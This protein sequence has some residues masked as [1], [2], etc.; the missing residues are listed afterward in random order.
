MS[1]ATSAACDCKIG[2]NAEAYGL[3]ALDSDIRRRRE[4][5]ASLRS[6][7]G[8]VNVRLL[9]AEL[10]EADADVVGDAESVYEAIEGDDVAPERR[11]D[12]RDQLSYAGVDLTALRDDFVSHQTVSAHLNDCLGLDTSRRGVTTVEEA[13]DLI[14]WASDKEERTIEQTLA[15]LV[16]NGTLTLGDL[17][18]TLS[19]TVRCADCGDSFRVP[20][21][22]ERRRCSCCL[23]K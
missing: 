9:E 7:A 14:A 13:R 6:L 3:D 5:G 18:V 10:L 23:P 22:L 21:I 16:R 8:Y 15:Q 12:V 4:D 17:E 11:A 2:R 20:E 19:V 1:D